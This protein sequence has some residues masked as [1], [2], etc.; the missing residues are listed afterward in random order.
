MVKNVF[1]HIKRLTPKVVPLL[2]QGLF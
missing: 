1:S 2:M